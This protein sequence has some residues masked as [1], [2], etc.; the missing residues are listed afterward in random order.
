MQGDNSAVIIKISKNK[1]RLIIKIAVSL[2]LVSV[3]VC[4]LYTIRQNDIELAKLEKMPVDEYYMELPEVDYGEYG[5]K[6]ISENKKLSLLAN[7]PT[8]EIALKDNKTGKIWYSNPQDRK[9]DQLAVMA[10]RSSSQLLVQFIDMESSNEFTVDSYLGCVLKGGLDYE[11]KEN[12]IKFI[13]RFPNHGMVLPVEYTL[14]EDCFEAKILMDEVEEQNSDAYKIINISV[15]PFFSAGGVKDDGYIFIPDGSG[16]LINYNNGK[17]N[18]NEYSEMIYGNDITISNEK[19]NDITQKI[20]LPVFGNKTNSQGFL[21]IVTSGEASGVIN[22]AVSGVTTGYNQVYASVNYREI[23]ITRID[24]HGSERQL[25]QYG[26]CNLEGTD[27]A[28]KYYPLE[29]EKANY[30]G[31]AACYR[32]YL[33]NTGVLDEKINTT[34]GLALEIYGAVITKKNVIGV[35]KDIVTSLTDYSDMYKLCSDLH[36]DGVKNIE[37]LYKGWNK[38]GLKAPT[39]TSVSYEKELGSKKEL[40][41]LLEVANKNGFKLYLDADFSNLY[42]NG[43]GFSHV[44]D[45][46]RLFSQDSAKVFEFKY[47]SGEANEDLSRYLIRPILFGELAEKFSNSAKKIGNVN[48]AETSF[49]EQLFSDFSK[50]GTLRYQSKEKITDTLKLMGKNIENL[51]VTGGNIYAVLSADTIFD[52]PCE[53]SD[54]D[55][56]DETVPFYSMVLHGYK[57]LTTSAVNF[58]E[59]QQKALLKAIEMGCT[60]KYTFLNGDTSVLIGTQYSDLFNSKLSN[61]YATAVEQYKGNYKILEKISGLEIVMHKKIAENIYSTSY[62][63]GTVITVNYGNTAVKIGETEIAAMG[64]AVESQGG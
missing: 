11:L 41:K 10:T 47:A 1:I 3:I 15:L 36:N 60:P 6:I 52:V 43:N 16:A 56:V 42:K 49:G 14:F 28:V 32:D 30:S 45:A 25:K 61:G 57:Q 18:C 19:S 12:G 22:A 24:R 35:E 37:I 17:I 9:E 7:I 40:L 64:Y 20:R 53:S 54:F 2:F 46:A 55:I 50:D 31:M 13:Y 51:A 8:G 33:K 59:N 34:A 5:F 62:E 29:D 21:G 27:F 63:D 38:G 26:N 48:I 58:S 44:S 39:A 23:F 4:S